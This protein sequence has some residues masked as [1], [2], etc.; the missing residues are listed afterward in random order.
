MML[1]MRGSD[2]LNVVINSMRLGLLTSLVSK[3]SLRRGDVGGASCLFGDEVAVVT[4]FKEVSGELSSASIKR[5]L[6]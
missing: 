1:E 4:P 5:S 3:V 2:G 6:R